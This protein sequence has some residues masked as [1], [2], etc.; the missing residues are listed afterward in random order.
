MAEPDKQKEIVKFFL[1]NDILL[2]PDVIAQLSQDPDRIHNLINEK[3][4]KDDFFFLN[5][6]V[7][8]LLSKN[9]SL[10][11]NW[12]DFEKLLAIAEKQKRNDGYE[13][14]VEALSDDEKDKD[15][16][17]SA[18]DVNVLFS[19][20]EI[21][22][23]IEVQHFVSYFIERYKAI[24]KML[25]TRA[26]LSNI[27]S[28]NRIN[29][30]REKENVSLIGIVSDKQVTKN[31]N[32]M[33]TLEDTTG[34]IKVIVN[35]SKP[36]LYDQAKDI[37]LDEVI[38][39]TGANSDKIVFANS[40][41][42]PEVPTDR[43]LKKSIEEEHAVFLSDLHIGSRFFLEEEFLGFINWINCG[44]GTTEQIEMAKKVKYIVIV[45]D[46]VDGVGIYPGQEK[47]LV[48]LDIYKQYEKCAELLKQIPQHIK[49]VICAGNHDAMRIS[50]PQLELYKDFAASLW[51]MPNVTMVSNPGMINIGS[52]ATFKGMD[53]LLYH[54][55]SFDH[56]VAEVESIR[57]NGGYNNPELIMKFLLKRRH[58]AP[59]HS[60][61]LY[62][63]DANRDP[64]VINKIP[65]F[66]VTGH[67]HKC[68]VSNYRNITM[69]CGS[70]WQSKTTF[71][72]KMGHVPEPC[73]VPIVNLKTRNVKLLKFGD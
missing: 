21:P 8:G 39:I 31:Q 25:A 72:E 48:I 69:I 30:K 4:K 66:F 63:P 17:T 7:T 9:K 34:T 64:L 33:L 11:I 2:A 24:E 52:K 42:W 15:T 50:E 40:I 56:Y 35:K 71:Q 37:V 49:I 38:G 47:E 26:E 53:I 59:T 16:R 62:M 29:S 10:D 51:E 68:S 55:Y 5:K 28:I 67:I 6:D 61:T 60:S 54:G 43:E 36:E 12:N 41:V 3:I 20:K 45:G 70:C 57:N 23:K 19:Y 65:D 58:L 14:T 44:K 13:K 32:I 27:L 22:K 73:R 18:T 46:L 1:N